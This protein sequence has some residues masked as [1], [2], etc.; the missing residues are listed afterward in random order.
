MKITEL[1]K[2]HNL[3]AI[4][5]YNESS[6]KVYEGDSLAFELPGLELAKD[7]TPEGTEKLVRKYIE[8]YEATKN[9]G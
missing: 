3:E 1:L 8:E 5:S 9:N 7:M 4:R 2:S 6:V